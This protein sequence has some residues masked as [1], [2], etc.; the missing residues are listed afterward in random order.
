MGLGLIKVF[1]TIS[2]I[3][4]LGGVS[5]F[6]AHKGTQVT[7]KEVLE[8]ECLPS[9]IERDTDNLWQKAHKKLKTSSPAENSRFFDLNGSE[10][11]ENG[12]KSRCL[13]IY[14]ENYSSIFYKQ[15][16]LLNDVK[17]YCSLTLE[18]SLDEDK[19]IKITEEESGEDKTVFEKLIKTVET[20]PI[21]PKLQG[22]N[23]DWKELR[24]LCKGFYGEKYTNKSQE[25]WD[26]VKKYCVKNR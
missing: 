14:K 5:A 25:T 11:A 20:E 26:L 24:K 6:G 4:A 22:L 10:N 7:F 8:N 2:G 1:S 3:V 17:K 12:L 15:E 13:E 18:E 16:D 23:S 9:D 21:N 19:R